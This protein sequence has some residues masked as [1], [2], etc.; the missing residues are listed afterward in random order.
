[1]RT[2]T[3]IKE[4]GFKILKEKLGVVEMEKFIALINREN[5]NYTKWRKNLFEDMSIDELADKAQKFSTSF[6]D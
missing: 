2:D 3:I 1:M 4:D 6:N 5:F